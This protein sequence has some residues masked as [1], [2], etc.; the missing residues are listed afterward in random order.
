MVFFVF[1]PA[2]RTFFFN[3]SNQL[4]A[5]HDL[6]H[7]STRSSL[8]SGCGA[9]L[10]WLL[11][12]TSHIWAGFVAC[13]ETVCVKSKRQVAF[14]GL[15]QKQWLLLRREIFFNLGAFIN[16]YWRTGSVALDST[17]H[18]WSPKYWTALLSFCLISFIWSL[19]AGCQ[20][21]VWRGSDG[22]LFHGGVHWGALQSKN[23][24]LRQQGRIVINVSQGKCEQGKSAGENLI[25][26][27]SILKASAL[28]YLMN[29]IFSG[30]AL[31]QWSWDQCVRLSDTE[32]Q[33]AHSRQ[34]HPRAVSH[35][36]AR[37]SRLPPDTCLY[38]CCGCECLQLLFFCI[39]SHFRS[40]YFCLFVWLLSSFDFVDSWDFQY[41][42]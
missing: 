2:Q 30:G 18:T 8:V 42:L 26:M 11:F 22:S 31:I 14:G 36:W 5:L 33:K 1:L 39:I 27:H 12:C 4:T 20:H 29:C 24:H 3:L 28:W 40:D 25:E 35:E 9:S 37:W 21:G 23:N 10:L 38:C 6:K 16:Y 17:G 13:R 34:Q 32:N 7:F 19:C 15:S 41:Y